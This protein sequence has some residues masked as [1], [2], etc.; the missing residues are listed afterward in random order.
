MMPISRRAAQRPASWLAK[1]GTPHPI[2]S[3]R[4]AGHKRV[5]LTTPAARHGRRPASNG[6]PRSLLPEAV[7][8]GGISMGT[9]ALMQKDI[10]Y[11]NSET[12]LLRRIVLFMFNSP[13]VPTPIGPHST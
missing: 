4:Q 9:P 6:T 13:S 3:S 12:K 7:Q 2:L 10:G 1:D 5:S 11:K 8:L